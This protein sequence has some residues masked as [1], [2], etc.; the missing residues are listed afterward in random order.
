MTPILSRGHRHSTFDRD[1]GRWGSTPCRDDIRPIRGLISHRVHEPARR[2]KPGQPPQTQ[3]ADAQSLEP[4][5]A[6]HVVVCGC[7]FH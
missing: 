5:P 3:A 2:R 1:R 7:C 4:R 6:L